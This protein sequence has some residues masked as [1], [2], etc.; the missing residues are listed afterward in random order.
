MSWLDDL[1]RE[2]QRKQSESRQ[3]S[4]SMAWAS[5]RTPSMANRLVEQLKSDAELANSRLG[6]RLK[7]HLDATKFQIVRSE[8]P[9]VFLELKVPARGLMH[10]DPVT[11]KGVKTRHRVL[12]P[13]N[14]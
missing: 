7:I 6:I 4:D 14:E 10:C 11:L 8:Y 9:S 2:G 12:R 5:V 13:E 1:E 3:K